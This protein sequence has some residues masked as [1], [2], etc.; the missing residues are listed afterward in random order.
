MNEYLTKDGPECKRRLT[1]VYAKE[2]VEFN[3]LV[4][5]QLDPLNAFSQK[6]EESE[7]VMGRAY[8]YGLMYKSANTLM[9]AM[10]LA[11]SGYR[12]EPPILHRN[13]L[14]GCAV[15]WDLVFNEKSFQRWQNNKH[16]KSTD[17]VGR[18]FKVDEF[19]GWIWGRLSNMTVHTTKE[20]ARPPLFR[21]PRGLI[22]Q[23][24]GYI[25]QGEEEAAR[26]TVESTIMAAHACLLLTEVVFEPFVTDPEATAKTN[27]GFA[28]RKITERHQVFVDRFQETLK[29]SEQAQT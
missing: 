18:L 10:E 5:K 12:W 23:P 7:Q 28:T 17:S 13:A 27:E 11:L 29:R 4:R 16:F 8:A 15:A 24:F 26:Y 3:Y 14:E 22:Y 21:T 20:N 19:Y 9:A 6:G 1:H 25:R 2:V